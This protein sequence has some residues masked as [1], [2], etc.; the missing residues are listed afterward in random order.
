MGNNMI[1]FIIYG[2][3]RG[4]KNQMKTTRTGRH[5]PN[6]S[7]AR[8]RDETVIQIADGDGWGESAIAMPC[9]VTVRYWSGDHRRRDVPGM[10]DALWHC[11]EHGG[12]VKDDALLETV[13]WVYE[14][15]DK[16]NP[17]V[18]VVIEAI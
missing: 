17:R 11:L 6:P 1:S 14:G 7:W 4:G 2:I 18:Q 8:W 3:I 13:F 10:I 12:F 9:R 15:Y 16:K 5:Y